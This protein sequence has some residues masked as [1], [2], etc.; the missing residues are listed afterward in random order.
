MEIHP[1]DELKGAHR[2]ATFVGMAM[3]FSLIIYVILVEFM[4]VDIKG[5]TAPVIVEILRF[6]FFGLAFVE[7]FVIRFLRK[8]LLPLKGVTESSSNRP[9]AFSPIIQKLFMATIITYAL[10]ESIAIY[11]LILFLIG[12]SRFDFYIF[13][14]LSLIYFAVYF[15]RYSRWEDWL[16]AVYANSGIQSI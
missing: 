16:K 1:F 12:G 5:N 4:K 10:C 7:F 13:L 15:P 11:G 14:I 6:L 3:I 8:Q 9:Q 2:K